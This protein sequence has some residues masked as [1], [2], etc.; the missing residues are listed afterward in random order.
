MLSILYHVLTYF[1]FIEKYYRCTI[2]A[3]ILIGVHCTAEPLTLFLRCHL[4]Y[5]YQRD[6]FHSSIDY[7]SYL[8]TLRGKNCVFG[9]TIQNCKGATLKLGLIQFDLSHRYLYALLI[10]LSVKYTIQNNTG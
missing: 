1:T 4:Q 5:S 6:Y 8:P 9:I 7:I 10:S 3:I 2:Y